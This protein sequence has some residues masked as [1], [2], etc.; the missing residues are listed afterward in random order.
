MSSILSILYQSIVIIWKIY[1]YKFKS[2][3]K[4]IEVEICIEC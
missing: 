3:K 4:N 2:V 1:A